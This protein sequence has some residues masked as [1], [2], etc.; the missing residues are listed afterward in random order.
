LTG[1]KWHEQESLHKGKYKKE[2]YEK[3]FIPRKRGTR[4][5]KE[6]V[7]IVKYTYYGKV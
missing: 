2:K 5:E 3:V 4:T 6:K 1:K 7:K